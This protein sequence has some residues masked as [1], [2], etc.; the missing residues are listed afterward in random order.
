MIRI[1]TNRYAKSCCN[2]KKTVDVD[3]GFAVNDVKWLTYHKE[4]LPKQNV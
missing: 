2:C 3:D 1:I 4:C